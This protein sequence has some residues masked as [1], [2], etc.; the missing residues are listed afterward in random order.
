[1]TFKS[2]IFIPYPAHNTVSSKW[3]WQYQRDNE[4]LQLGEP[5]CGSVLYTAISIITRCKYVSSLHVGCRHILTVMCVF[6]VHYT[7]LGVSLS[8]RAL[9][10]LQSPM[11]YSL[12]S[13]I[14]SSTHTSGLFI[15]HFLIC[16]VSVAGNQIV[17]MR[18][19]QSLLNPS[20]TCQFCCGGIF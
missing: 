14:T 6:M 17:V 11:H 12:P 19:D 4:Q 10:P 2:A 20:P 8:S 15:C 13:S 3:C 9:A 1:M 16:L 18:C 7:S 5:L